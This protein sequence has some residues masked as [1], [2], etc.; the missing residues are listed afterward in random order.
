M[1]SGSFCN[2]IF[3]SGAHLLLLHIS[4]DKN[5][6]TGPLLVREIRHNPFIAERINLHKPD[7]LELDNLPEF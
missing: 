5:G 7:P 2:I 6:L 3:L 1:Y 4:D